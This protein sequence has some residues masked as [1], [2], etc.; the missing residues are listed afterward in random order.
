MK[1]QKEFDRTFY[2][3]KGMLADP[4]DN[5][6]MELAIAA[7]EN[8]GDDNPKAQ[9]NFRKAVVLLLGILVESEQVKQM[10]AIDAALGDDGEED[11]DGSN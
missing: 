6:P 5:I 4:F 1:N 8:V 2:N 10:A 9:E 7:A 11:D 3:A